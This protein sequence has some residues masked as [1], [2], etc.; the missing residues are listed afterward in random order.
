MAER[1]RERLSATANDL[2]GSEPGEL[3]PPPSPWRQ[4]L[5]DA[6]QLLQRLGYDIAVG[7]EGALSHQLQCRVCLAAAAL[8]AELGQ[9]RKASFYLLDV[10]RRCRIEGH[11]L[12]R[13]GDAA[14][15]TLTLTHSPS[16]RPPPRPTGRRRGMHR[17]ALRSP[18]RSHSPQ[19]SPQPSPGAQ[20]VAL[21][22]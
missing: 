2:M 14:A 12:D 10:A 9:P 3:P 18:S 22:P 4:R 11:R 17:V 16:L 8:S 19:T 21:G 5:I 13:L 1:E 7:A 15:R 20:R 6:Q